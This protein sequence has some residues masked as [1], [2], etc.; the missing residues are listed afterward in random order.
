MDIEIGPARTALCSKMVRVFADKLCEPAAC[1][2]SVQIGFFFDGTENN[3]NS[4]RASRSHTNIARLAAAYPKIP[5]LNIRSVYI[6]AVGTSFD[7]LAIEEGDEWFGPAFGVGCEIR[8]HYACAMLLNTLYRTLMSR[9]LFPIESNHQMRGLCGS[10]A[11]SED[12]K[13]DISLQLLSSHGVML[14]HATRISKVKIKQCII[15]VFGF[16]RGA[17]TARAFCNRLKNQMQGTYFGIPLTFRFLGLFDTVSAAGLGGRTGWAAPKNLVVPKDVQNCVHMV[18]M[19]EL[20]S[21]FPVEL[22]DPTSPHWLELA[23]PGAHSDVGGGYRPGQLGVPYRTPSIERESLQLSQVALHHMY[24]LARA[25]GVPLR[26]QVRSDFLINPRLEQDYDQ[27][28]THLG[29]QKRRLY[30]WLEHYLLWRWQSRDIYRASSQVKAASDS[31]RRI[32]LDHHQ[33]FIDQASLISGKIGISERLKRLY[34]P[35]HSPKRAIQHLSLSDE[36]KTI[37]RRV[38]RAKPLPP[39]ISNFFDCYVHDSLAGFN[40]Q[41][42]EPEGYWRY[43][44]AFRGS[45]ERFI[46]A[47]SVD[48]AATIA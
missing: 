19:H 13:E 12:D 36:A 48:E 11:Q 17:A 41:I 32:M 46:A 44:R 6:P 18:A 34:I 42:L 33:W 15:D 40:R 20:R 22:I 25:A 31:D 38:A 29:E 47:N 9:D 28:I 3:A 26:I 30:E 7:Q 45:D 8:M 1:E 43:R 39:S 10:W 5:D 4:H 2:T 14:Q 23:Y 35:W 37:Y 24:A 16:S 21:N 27:F